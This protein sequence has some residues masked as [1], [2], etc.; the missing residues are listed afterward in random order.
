MRDFMPIIDPFNT[1][2]LINA[3]AIDFPVVQMFANIVNLLYVVFGG[4]I[5]ISIIFFLFR[6]REMYLLRKRLENVEIAVNLINQKLDKILKK[7]K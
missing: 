5:G 4:I 1:Q 7:K 3:T 2:Q 6:W